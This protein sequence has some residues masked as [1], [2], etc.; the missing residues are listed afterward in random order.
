MNN[1]TFDERLQR[2]WQWCDK[3]FARK[4]KEFK[5]IGWRIGLDTSSASKRFL[6]YCD[7]NTKM[8][9]MSFYFLRGPT[10]SESKMR[11]TI[12]HEIAH[13]LVGPFQSHNFIWK[14]KAK[15]IGCTGEKAGVMDHPSAKYII[16]CKNKCFKYSSVNKMDINNVI[17]GKC[18][19]KLYIKSLR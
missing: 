1:S 12:L 19:T 8:I 6:G 15:K 16:F 13:A 18:K 9:M 4:I 5:L 10:C 11:N 17:C 2:N 14:N 3:Y 7:Y